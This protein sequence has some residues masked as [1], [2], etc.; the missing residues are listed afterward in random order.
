MQII[1]WIFIGL[2]ALFILLGLLIG[3]G[4]GLRF[5]TKGFFGFIISI[6][7]C[8]FIGALIIKISFIGSETGLLASFRAL[9]EGKDV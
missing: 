7:I 4:K 5:F 6:I 9:Y 1:D 2:I 8:Y 3:F